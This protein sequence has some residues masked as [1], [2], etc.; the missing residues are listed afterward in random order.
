MSQGTRL[1]GFAH[2]VFTFFF[3]ALLLASPRHHALAQLACTGD[4]NNNGSVT[5]G[6]IIT[7]V[8]INL[9]ALPLSACQVFDQDGTGKVEIYELIAGVNSLLSGCVPGPTATP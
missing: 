8:N 6:E 4:C 9:N 5:V 2:L 3:A 7:G 1:R